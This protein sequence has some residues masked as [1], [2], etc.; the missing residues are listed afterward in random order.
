MNQTNQTQRRENYEM[1]IEDREIPE[2]I[3]RTEEDLLRL[4]SERQ[5]RSASRIL[6]N[7]LDEL[8]I[9]NRRGK[10]QKQK[11]LNLLESNK[12]KYNENTDYPF[13]EYFKFLILNLSFTLDVVF[14]DLYEEFKNGILTLEKYT[15]EKKIMWAVHRHIIMRILDSDFTQSCITFFRQHNYYGLLDKQI[16]LE[17]YNQLF[18][19]SMWFNSIVC[20]KLL[21]VKYLH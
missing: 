4:E 2:R 16:L 21:Y 11:Y 17:K 10:K 13:E 3:M 18:N 5:Q 19:Y 6:K 1:N 14:G 20:T 9:K 15:R 12:Q 7:G 8:K